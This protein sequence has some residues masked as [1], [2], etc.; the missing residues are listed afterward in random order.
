VNIDTYFSDLM[1][2]HEMGNATEHSYRRVLQDLFDQI[3]PDVKSQ[4]EPE[5]L[6]DVGAPDFSFH[7]GSVVMG[8]AEA[9]IL[10]ADLKGLKGREKDQLERYRKAL[11]NLI[12]TDGLLFLFY[13]DGDLLHEVRIGE[14]LMGWKAHPDQFD[15]LEHALKDFANR[16]PRTIT[17]PAVLATL[18]AGKAA[19]IKDILGRSLVADKDQKTELTS[20]FEAFRDQLIHDITID[21]FAGM[22]AET[23]AYGLFAARLHDDTPDTFSRSEALDLLPKSNPFLRNLFGYVA[24]QNLD[25]RLRWIVDDLAAIFLAVDRDKLMRG[26]GRLTGR[27]DPFL[28][29]YETFLAAYDPKKRKARGV[30]YTPE[31][32]VNFIVRAVDEVLQT[33]FGLPLGLAD[34]SKI[35]IDWETGQTSKNGKRETIKKEVHRVQILDPATGTGTFLA[36]VIKQIAPRIKD[37]APG[38]WNGYVER[39]LIPRLHGFEL[40][41]AS[42]AMCHMKLDMM[43]REM[44][45]VPT[46]SPPR[47]NV[48]LTNS[49]E[50]GEPANQSLPFAQWLSNEVKEAN[51][52]KRDMP[53][54]CV[55]GNPP[56][57]GISHNNG[58]WISGLIEDYKYVDGVHF[59]E[60]KHWLQD[61]YV[62]FI[63][64]SEHLIEKNGEGILGFITNHGYLDNPT[65]RGMRWHLMQ[66]FDK[67]HVLDLH[68]NA[69]RRETTPDGDAD[70]NV[71]DI[72][73]GVA[74]VIAVKKKGASNGVASVTHG[75][76]WG[77][78]SA[79]YEALNNSVQSS[80]MSVE[81]ECAKP[82]FPFVPRENALA[83]VYETGIPLEKFM[84]EN[85]TGIVTAKDGLVIDFSRDQLEHKISRFAERDKTDSQVRSDFF[86]NKTSGKYAAGDSRGWK[87]PDARIALQNSDWQEDITNICYRP[88]DTRAILYRPDMVDWGRFEAM[89]N[90]MMPNNF[91]LV[92]SRQ[93][94]RA[95]A[96]PV[97]VFVSDEIFD[98][99]GVYSNKGIAQSAPLYIYPDE[100]DLD[101]TRRV[102]F[103]PK[104]WKDLKARA[105]HPVHGTPDEV[106][107]F[108]YIYGVLHAP[109][110]RETYA[111]FLKI[112]FPRI[113][114]PATPDAFWSIA[115]KGEALRM[116]HLMDPAA[117]GATPYPFTGDGDNVVDRPR[118]EDGKVWINSTQS[119]DAAP[120]VSWDLYIGGYQP[121]QKWLKDRKGREL[122]FED[123]QHYQRIIKIL[124]ETDRIMGTIE[125]DL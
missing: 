45:Y 18:M 66:T 96:P 34:T 62:K 110:Y 15:A 9:K 95:N 11:P 70:M 14:Y 48:F 106:Q 122:G 119:F 49:L 44:G 53:I 17:S 31:P 105:T 75:E 78:R 86:P 43:L 97:N 114:W 103:D 113:P 79:K 5:R 98:N 65:F 93:A 116:L 59:G 90:L 16:T 124:S 72:Q 115:A 51:T 87:L 3:T 82:Q 54:M 6:R 112:D 80:L 19:L 46:G 12:Y 91:G 68:G 77:A 89:R 39:E 74:I 10:G 121:A 55:I 109:S 47:L 8:H 83:D 56:Y 94:V 104:L 26:F 92:F 27:Q 69:N 25:D 32:V 33:E 35:K 102:N 28:H 22:Y 50:E 101:Q 64:M 123:I 29:F 88:F 21:D 20:Q 120:L 71:F 125:M 30:W 61:D 7:R 42:Y 13:R 38:Q 111:E 2:V 108:D 57:S 76:L 81:L 118:Y 73:Q 24:G 4:N 1:A 60:R 40:L 41:M 84:T 67:I 100:Q 99:R 63:R 36:E 58:P 107:T 85:V 23:V 52:V 117:I 37:I